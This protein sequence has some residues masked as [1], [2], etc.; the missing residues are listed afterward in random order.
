MTKIDIFR[1]KHGNIAKFECEGHSGYAETGSDIVCASVTSV[2]YAA[3][4]GIENVLGIS[5]GYE[6]GDGYILCVMPED[7]NEIDT[8]NFVKLSLGDV[9]MDIASGSIYTPNTNTKVTHD[10]IEMNQSNVNMNQNGAKMNQEN[11]NINQKDVSMHQNA[12]K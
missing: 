3:M 1:D 11:I 10:D 8:L 7:L 9:L 2:I 6:Q 5:F 4:N 12:P